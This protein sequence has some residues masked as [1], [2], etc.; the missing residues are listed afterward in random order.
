MKKLFALLLA[1]TLLLSGCSSNTATDSFAGGTFTGVGT[2]Y[3]SEI[4]LEVTLNA[5]KEIKEVKVLSEAE[6]ATIGSK[7]L[8]VY[9]EEVVNAGSLDIDTVSGAT[10]TYDGF[11]LGMN[12]ALETA[13][14]TAADLK[15]KDKDS[16]LVEDVI[17]D[18]DVV[19][20]GAGGAGLTAGTIASENGAKV[21]ILEKAAFVGGNTTRATG[22]MN[23]AATVYQNAVEIDDSIELFVADTMAGG[24]DLNNPE[25]VQIMAENSSDAIDWLTSI[26][27]VF[28][29]V[30]KFGGASVKRGHRPVDEN[31]LKLP[32]GNIMVEKLEAAAINAGVNIMTETTVNSIIMTDGVATGV[33]ATA[34]DGH[35]VTV[36]AKAVI[37]AAGGFGANNDLVATYKPELKGYVTTNAPTIT[38]DGIV[39]G[40]AVGA[41]LVDIDQ[42]QI[43]P[44]VRQEDGA[45]ITESLRGDGSILINAEGNRFIDEMSTRDIVSAAENTQ[46]GSFSWLIV[47]QEMYDNS[48]VIQGYD[49]KGYWV[50][51]E[52]LEELAVNTNVDAANLQ[53]A[54]DGWHTS[55]E[56][57][58][59]EFGRN[60]EGIDL[61]LSTAPYYAVKVSPGVH[62]TMGGIEINVNAEVI[63]TD[64]EV[65]PGL[66]AAGEVTG[67]IHGA[68]RLGGNALADISVF[69][70]IAGE[71]AAALIAE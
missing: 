31:G 29:N 62:H 43:H 32:V 54:L 47:D 51:G 23:A 71:N 34:T 21:I 1:S 68:N 17:L 65:I 4:E 61:T 20:I 46:T 64:G 25:L 13:G 66:F 40:E 45:L 19:I 57:G 70:H 52:T 42:I 63:N 22:G 50:K 6:T 56:T 37:I 44:T 33:V 60:V 5:D 41:N 15:I 53:A 3:S 58:T 10:V 27:A 24:K 11:I 26:G 18:T 28:D 38:G 36:N 12:A 59:D 8:T 7:A 55:L 49:A 30:T 16:T 69:G 48:G 9:V 35:T 2:G 14:L 39:M 67:G